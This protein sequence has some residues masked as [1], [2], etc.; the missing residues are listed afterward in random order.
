[1][2]IGVFHVPKGEHSAN[3]MKQR[4]LTNHCPNPASHFGT[5][6]ARGNA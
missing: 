2:G 4:Y 6:A 5:L 3:P 1:M